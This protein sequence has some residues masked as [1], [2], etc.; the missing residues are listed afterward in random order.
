MYG[1]VAAKLPFEPADFITGMSHRNI[2][3]EDMRECSLMFILLLA[4]TA[5]R[6]NITKMLGTEGPRMPLDHQTPKWL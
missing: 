2:P 6:G 3:G 4:Q 1:I 5:F